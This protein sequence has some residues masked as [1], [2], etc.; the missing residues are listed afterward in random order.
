LNEAE[1]AW[2]H[3]FTP[4]GQHRANTW[5]GEFPSQNLGSDGYDAPRR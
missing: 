5:Q 1:Y 2:G 3:E 4:G